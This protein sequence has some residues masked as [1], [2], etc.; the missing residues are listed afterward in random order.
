M[1]KIYLKHNSIVSKIAAKLLKMPAGKQLATTIGHTIHLLNTDAHYFAARRDWIRH[2]L[3]HVIQAE[4]VRFFYIKYVWE[5]IR[6]G[7]HRNRFELEA[8][9][10]RN[11]ALPKRYY[12]VDKNTLIVHSDTWKE[13]FQSN[14]VNL[15]QMNSTFNTNFSAIPDIILLE[16]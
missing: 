10:L 7:Y 6:K 3:Q 8:D 4:T 15:N 11:T 14:T 5:S 2:E 13:H 12:F 1:K 16:K 9:N